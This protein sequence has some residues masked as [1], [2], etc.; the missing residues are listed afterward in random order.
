MK[1][2]SILLLYLG[3]L[4]SSCRID[5]HD[6][7]LQINENPPQDLVRNFEFE[8]NEFIDSYCAFITD[9][10]IILAWETNHKVYLVSL[11]ADA[12]VL[13]IAADWALVKFSNNRL[14]TLIIDRKI[15]SAQQ[16]LELET[17]LTHD[18]KKIISGEDI[19]PDEIEEHIGDKIW[20]LK[21]DWEFEKPDLGLQSV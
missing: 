9:S 15:L 17:I 16:L 10:D 3:V 7:Y 19:T 2:L 6:R 1:K 20:Q 4:L 8:R 21:P 11:P 14:L 13:S 12:E 18:A 5:Y